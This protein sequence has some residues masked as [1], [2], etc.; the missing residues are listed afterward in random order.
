MEV[1]TVTLKKAFFILEH[2]SSEGEDKYLEAVKTI[3]EKCLSVVRCKD[4]KHKGWV[5]EPCHGK[6]VDYCKV[7]DC[8][9]RNLKTTFCSYGERKESDNQ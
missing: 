9:L 4:C 7:W 5:Q 1:L 2:G 8:T 6:S 3:R